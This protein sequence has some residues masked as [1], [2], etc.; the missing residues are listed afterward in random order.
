V[1]G[2]PGAPE[3]VLSAVLANGLL[4]C[5]SAARHLR[6]WVLNEP[7]VPHL[8]CR[9]GAAKGFIVHRETYVP[10]K[11]PLAVASVADT[12]LHALRCLPEVEAVVMVESA[13]IQGRTTVEF[14]RGKLWGNRNG[15]ARRALVSVEGSAES[16]IE[17]VA[18]LLFR[19]AG[20]RV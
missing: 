6:L 14:L 5:A 9:H 16:P 7:E 20:I 15:A 4:T 18:R 12:L 3:D 17:V 19:G 13:V 2:L 1:L 11:G 10:A 8:F